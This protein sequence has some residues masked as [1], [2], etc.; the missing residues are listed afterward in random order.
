[1]CGSG[2]IVIEAAMVAADMA[3][4]MLRPMAFERWPFF[5]ERLQRGWASL[6][7][8]AAQRKR[9][10]LRGILGG[11]DSDMAAVAA[12]RANAA[13]LGIDG[14][15]FHQRDATRLEPVLGGATLVCNPPYGERVGGEKADVDELMRNFSAA[16]QR[17]QGHP[18]TMIAP[19]AAIRA[20][21]VKPARQ[22]RVS[23]GKIPCKF[24]H[25]PG[26]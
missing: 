4:G 24:V 7:D 13:V 12:A 21:G 18:L 16:W 20:F 6:R 8:E 5:A 22:V 10:K 26:A 3:P 2:T 9:P 14:L 17:L 15:V 11:G 1:M 23:N 25:F 19:D